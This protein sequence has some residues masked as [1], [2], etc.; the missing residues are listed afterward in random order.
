M[1]ITN[2]VIINLKLIYKFI[3]TNQKI[4]KEREEKRQL[5]FVWVW[6]SECYSDQEIHV[7]KTQSHV[8]WRVNVIKFFWNVSFKMSIKKSVFSLASCYSFFNCFRLH[9]F[10]TEYKFNFITRSANFCKT[11]VVFQLNSPLL[12]FVTSTGCTLNSQRPFCLVW[13]HAKALVEML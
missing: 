6:L 10:N 13:F 3:D 1:L 7:A 4:L 8:N 11:L 12:F 5:L 9:S 2:D